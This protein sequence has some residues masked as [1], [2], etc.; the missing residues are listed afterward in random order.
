[1]EILEIL[2]IILISVLIGVFIIDVVL[3][4]I[5]GIIEGKRQAEL[6]RRLC[7]IEDLLSGGTGGCEAIG[8]NIE[9]GD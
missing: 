1:M 4:F 7:S 2:L 5:N 3:G 6:E 8:F 9:D